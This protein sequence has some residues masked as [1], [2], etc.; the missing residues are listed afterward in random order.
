MEESVAGGLGAPTLSMPG[1]FQNSEHSFLAERF[2]SVFPPKGKK[3]KLSA[4][5]VLTPSASVARDLL[6]SF[7]LRFPAPSRTL[8]G[9]NIGAGDSVGHVRR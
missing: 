9:S 5:S 2:D 8:G 7:P 4:K 3:G 1:E 6:S